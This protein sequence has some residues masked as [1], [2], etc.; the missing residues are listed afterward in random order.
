M[1]K[2]MAEALMDAEVDALCGAA[3][4]ERH[5]ERTNRRNGYRERAWDTRTGTIELAVPKL[6]AGSYFPF[7]HIA[8]A[9]DKSVNTGTPFR[10]S[11]EEGS[12]RS[13][14]TCNYVSPELTR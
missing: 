14:R 3:H 6:R 7:A 2:G 10:R 13:R 5:P 4:G 9:E 8:S 11:V 12:F 1:V